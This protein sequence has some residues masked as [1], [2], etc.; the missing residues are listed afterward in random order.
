MPTI[1]SGTDSDAMRSRH[2]STRMATCS[3]SSANS[4]FQLLGRQRPVR[5]Q[6]VE[7]SR[8]A[9][10]QWHAA[11]STTHAPYSRFSATATTVRFC[12]CFQERPLR[13]LVERAHR[14]AAPHLVIDLPARLAGCWPSGSTAPDTSGTPAPSGASRRS[15]PSATCAGSRRRKN[16]RVCFQISSNGGAEERLLQSG[17]LGAAGSRPARDACGIAR[18]ASPPA[19]GTWCR[20]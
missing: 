3:I 12:G 16:S 9:L 2:H 6:S 8:L 4:A 7:M 19:W 5:E 13:P 11:G 15:R 18:T 10:P 1:A 20:A 14:R 17:A